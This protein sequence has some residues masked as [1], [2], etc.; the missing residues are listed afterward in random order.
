[1]AMT[2]IN[3]I[4]ATAKDTLHRIFKI[5]RLRPWQEEVLPHI[6]AGKDVFVMVSTGAGKSIMYQYPASLD[7]EAELTLVISPTRSLQ[8]DQVDALN[9]KGLNAAL[10]NSDLTAD[11]RRNI[12]DHLDTY[13]LLYCAPEQLRSK[14]LLT[15][16]E[17]ITL[18]RV[19]ID[20][21]HILPEAKHSFRPAYN[22]IGKFIRSRSP[23]PQ[24]IALTA[25]A[26][27]KAR[28]QIK[29][30][31]KMKRNTATF[32]YPIR[33]TNLHIQ[34]KLIKPNKQAGLSESDV[35]LKTVENI[36]R[37]WDQKGSA[38]IYGTTVDQVDRAKDFLKGR[39]FKLKKVTGKMK[40][41][42][43]RKNQDAFMS[44][45]VSIMTATN[46][47]GLGVDKPDVRLVIH[48]GLPLTLEGYVQEVGRAGRDGKKSTC[49]LLYTQNDYKRN[50][51]ILQ[52]GG[53]EAFKWFEHGM[54]AMRGFVDDETSCAWK[55]IERYFGEKPKKRCKVCSNCIAN[56]LI[57]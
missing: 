43:R 45:K 47:F 32:V 57:R 25:T 5:S 38:I 14:D 22:E 17:R 4:P 18:R 53:D 21:A 19:V 11:E 9:R 46:A 8:M 34:T 41:E 39:G 49:V 6:L 36:L 51:R 12:L 54:K 3:I 55:K 31:L 13:T 20:E 35:M 30:D 42:K 10:L 33:R 48:M 16:L 37:Q 44:G 27:P 28:D 29:F 23:R 1:M 56:K 2:D 26:T 7:G 40:Y 15:A 24:V 50:K 52:A